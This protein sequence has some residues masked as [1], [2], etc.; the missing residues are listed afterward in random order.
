[1]KLKLSWYHVL[2]VMVTVFFGGMLST[3]PVHADDSL[4]QVKEKGVLTVATS[5]DYPPFGFE[6]NQNGKT[7][8]VGVD[9]DIAKQIAKDLG[10]KLKIKNMDFGSVLVAV[11]TGKAD[12]AIG[13]IN[14]TPERKANVDFS[15]NYYIGGQSFLINKSDAAKITNQNDLKNLKIGTKVGSLPYNLAKKNIPSAKVVGMDHTVDTVLALKSG[16]VNAIGLEKPVALGYA[17]SDPDLKIIKSDYKL[18]NDTL[19]AAIAVKKGDTSLLNAVNGSI[20]QIKQENLIPQYF[21]SAGKYMKVNVADTSMWHYWHYFYKGIQYTLLIS[22][23][24][25]FAGL[26]LG[27]ILVL[28]KL[29]DLKILKWIANSYVEVVRGT[30]MMV[31]V[32]LVYFGLGALINIPALLAGMIAVSLNSGAYICEIIRGGINSI[33]KGQHEAA[34]SLGLSKF[35]EMKSVILPQAFKNIWPAL[36]NEFISVIKESSIVSIIGI[37]E[38][39]YELNIVRADTY[40]GVAPIVV[41]M[42]LYFILTFT[43]SRGLSYL[44]KKMK[45]D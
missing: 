15:D 1:M 44:E 14:P 3:R 27:I 17:E 4:Q 18:D 30:P 40:R 19:G 8:E 6:A 25:V 9:I 29:G 2:I 11:Q 42:A 33:D 16:K 34:K 26:I 10:V 41:V 13:G 39:T 36:G 43:L 38:L 5:P 37:T 7:K 28:M 23:V 24:S 20:K 35:D 12:M 45:Y 31:Q 32:L 21:K 22:V